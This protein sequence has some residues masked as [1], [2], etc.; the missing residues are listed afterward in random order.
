EKSNDICHHL[1]LYCGGLFNV[2][3]HLFD[4]LF[5]THKL[6]DQ[7]AICT[8][9]CLCN[10]ALKD[11]NISWE[12]FTDCTDKGLICFFTDKME[13]GELPVNILRHVC[14]YFINPICLT[15]TLFDKFFRY[16]FFWMKEYIQ[17]ISLLDDF[18]IFH[19]CYLVTYFPD[20]MHFMRNS[21]NS[22]TQR[23]E[24]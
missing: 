21:N 5:L 6:N 9:L 20:H 24:E 10:V 14:Q 2:C 19:H 8:T 13:L 11:I 1:N 15:H 16:I 23:S 7:R 12:L 17:H 4:N 18:P 3:Y 22:Q